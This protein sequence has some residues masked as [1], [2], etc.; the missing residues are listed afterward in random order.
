M[1]MITRVS[2]VYTLRVFVLDL[3]RNGELQS[4]I[5]RLGSLSLACSRY[6]TAQLIDAL[7]YMHNKGVIHR[8]ATPH[9]NI[10]MPSN[11]TIETSNRRI[12]SLTTIFV[13][14]LRISGQARFS[15][16]AQ[17]VQRRG[18]APRS[19]SRLNYLI[20]A[21]R[22]RGAFG[23]FLAEL[24]VTF[25]CSSDLWSLGCILYQMISGKFT[26]QGLSEYLTWQKIKQL[27][28]TFPDGFNEQAKD[29]V[30]RLLVCTYTLC[31]AF[32]SS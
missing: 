11:L 29:L 31:L 28:Y 4:K 30:Q 24:E 13:L 16:V 1:L 27:D 12:F 19:I 9:L 17:N 26:F 23:L 2:D 25:L 21:R 3:A 20:V 5:S 6:Y 8:S 15:V 32:L 14:S 10:C 7:E 22:A 18:L